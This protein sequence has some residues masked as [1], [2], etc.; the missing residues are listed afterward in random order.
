MNIDEIAK[1][2][3]V[4]KTTVS[5]VLNNRP[6]VSK[7]T[8]DRINALIKYTGYTPNAFAKAINKKQANTIGLV[9]SQR[10][11]FGISLSSDR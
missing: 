1:L 3:G 2:A 7:E 10:L 4:S 5:R 6:D 8:A 11:S 9:I